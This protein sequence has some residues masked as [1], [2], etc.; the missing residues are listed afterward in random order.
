MAGINLPSI[1][2]ISDADLDDV[3]E[4]RRIMN[5]LIKL[6]EQLRYMMTHLGEEN[7]SQE[8][9]EAI[10]NGGTKRYCPCPFWPS[11]CAGLCSSTS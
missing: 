3:K 5:Y 8:T 4:R 6:D 10:R 7:F 2:R 9:V 1:P 11:T